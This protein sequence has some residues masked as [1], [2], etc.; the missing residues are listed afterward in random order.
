MSGNE[1]VEDT[2]TTMPLFSTNIIIAVIGASVL[3]IVIVVLTTLLIGLCICYWRRKRMRHTVYNQA[4][5]ALKVS[6]SINEASKFFVVESAH[7]ND[8][9]NCKSM[10]KEE[11]DLERISKPMVL[12]MANNPH[13]HKLTTNQEG[14][15]TPLGSTS[16]PVLMATTEPQNSNSPCPTTCNDS[17]PPDFVPM[18]N[19]SVVVTP[20]DNSNTLSFDLVMNCP[21]PPVRHESLVQ[22]CSTTPTSSVYQ[23]FIPRTQSEIQITGQNNYEIYGP[24]YSEPNKQLSKPQVK[25]K[26]VSISNIRLVK[27]LGMGQFGLVYLGETIGLSQKD[28]GMG[29]SENRSQS[30]QVAVKFLRPNPPPSEKVGFEKEI[31]F[32]SRLKHKNVVQ[33]LAACYRNHHFIVMEYMRHGDL[34]SFLQQFDSVAVTTETE[35]RVISHATLLK[36]SFQIADAMTYLAS[37]NFIHRDLATRNCLVGDNFDVKVADFGLS[38]NL[39]DSCYY[40]FQGSAMLP[41]RWMA[42]ECFFG[43]FSEKTDVWAFGVTMWEIFNLCKQRPYCDCTD[44]QIIIETLQNKRR[45]IE[46]PMFCDEIIYDIIKQCMKD[47]ATERLNFQQVFCKLSEIVS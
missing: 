7:K 5:T 14:T 27:D 42:N 29:P 13:Y 3:G 38:R 2:G 10:Q 24:I 34:Q 15:E 6:F 4:R 26:T 44:Q 45:L 35:N 36:M 17:N 23:H 9:I 47:E 39:Y 21:V 32:M 25:V 37:Q 31:K 28:L 46:K 40:R 33:L 30:F 41:I 18:C 43:R 22:S 1:P 20:P 12:N 11:H 8:Y 16:S 19:P